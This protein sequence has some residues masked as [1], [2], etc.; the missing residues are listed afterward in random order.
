LVVSL[1]V[2]CDIKGMAFAGV[3]SG[4]PLYRVC[5]ITPSVSHFL[6]YHAATTLLL[7]GHYLLGHECFL[8][9]RPRGRHGRYRRVSEKFPKYSR[10]FAALAG[11]CP[12]ARQ[13]RQ[14]RHG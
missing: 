8:G 13:C 5:H 3:L 7:P 4:A 9:R 6:F 1:V 2:A 12:L 14:F 11:K 10:G